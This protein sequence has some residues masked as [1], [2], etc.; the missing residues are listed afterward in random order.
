LPIVV[1]VCPATGTRKN[2]DD[3]VRVLVVPMGWARKG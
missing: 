2:R 3:K 1:I